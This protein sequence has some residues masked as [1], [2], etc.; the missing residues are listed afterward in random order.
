MCRGSLLYF[1]PLSR[2]S[3]RRVRDG[4][5]DSSFGAYG[6]KFPLPPSPVHV[7]YCMKLYQ[8]QK[9]STVEFTKRDYLV[10]TGIFSVLLTYETNYSYVQKCLVL[11][12]MHLIKMD[13]YYPS[14]S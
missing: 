1:L 5:D 14:L 8:S 12:S 4:T 13:Q 7:T 10:F 3:V 11:E 2:Y 6:V 9:F